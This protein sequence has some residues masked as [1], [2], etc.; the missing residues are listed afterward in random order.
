MKKKIYFVPFCLLMFSMFYV[1]GC[2][3]GQEWNAHPG[4]E[5]SFWIDVDLADN[6]GRGY[7]YPYA[8]LEENSVPSK[9]Q[10]MN[11]SRI[12]K[13]YGADKIYLVY[14]R[15]FEIDKFIGLLEEWKKNATSYD[16]EIVPS[17]V[18]QDYSESAGLNFTDDEL[19]SLAEWCTANINETEFGI[20]DV[21]IRQES[22]SPQDVQLAALRARTGCR[23]VRIGL[24]PGEALNPNC[25]SAV[26]DTWTA[27]CQGID[28]E[29]WQNPVTVGGT[30]IYGKKLL[31]SWVQERLDDNSTR[32]VWDLIPVAWDYDNPPDEFGY[33]CPGDDALINDPP[34]EGRLMLCHECIAG[35]YPSGMMTPEFGG[36]SCDLHILQANSAGR[37]E[38][39]SFYEQISAGKKYEGYFS[40]AMDQ[41]SEI[42]NSIRIKDRK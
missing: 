36:Y 20:Y 33:V 6:N 25:V 37:P 5:K 7:W 4:F 34:I 1:T 19:V 30:D 3:S 8:S 42:Y 26:E 12:L 27:E 40:G 22:G 2:V 16:L 14:H 15:Q 31:E 11:T 32:I 21:Y 13:E 18:L 41:I 39:P 10:I 23:L 24:Q 38:H 9:D 35:K 29:L 17:V 28:N